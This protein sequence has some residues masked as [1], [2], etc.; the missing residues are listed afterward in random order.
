MRNEFDK[1][2]TKTD[3]TLG[4]DPETDIILLDEDPDCFGVEKTPLVIK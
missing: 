3:V 4:K 2:K 1:E